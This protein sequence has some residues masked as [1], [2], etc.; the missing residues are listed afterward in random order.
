[1]TALD[2]LRVLADWNRD[3]EF[4]H[5]LSDISG[6]VLAA[7][8]SYGFNAPGQKMA[9][10]ATGQIVLDNNDGAFS[11][12][13][14]GALYGTVLR[15]DVLIQFQHTQGTTLGGYVITP[16]AMT[17]LRVI[18]I[19]IEPG[20]LSARTVV[21]TLGD[22]QSELMSAIYDP[23]LTLNTT[24]GVAIA[25]P[26]AEGLVPLSYAGQYWI[27]GASVLDTDTALFGPGQAYAS[28]YLGSTTLEYVG[29][30]IDRGG[31]VSLYSFIEEMCTAEMDGR[32]WLE[33]WP[34]YLGY[35]PR[36]RW[37]FM[38]RGDIARYYEPENTYTLPSSR[39]KNDGA[40]Y[41]YGR[42]ICNKVEVTLYPRTV[43]SVGTELGRSASTFRLKAGESRSITLRYRDPDNPD[44]TCSASTIIEPVASTDYTA[45]E[46]SDGSGADLT[47]SLSVV[48]E[49]RTSAAYLTVG[50]TGSTDL[51]VTLLKIRGTP[52]TAR[53]PVTIT[54]AD[55]QSI[56]DY[57]A[58][59]QS[60]TIAGVSDTELVQ[61]YA[62][63]Y[64]QRFK[65]PQARYRHVTFEFPENVSD[66]MY[67]PALILPLR[68]AGLRIEDDWIEDTTTTRI[69]WVAGVQHMVGGGT[70][71]TTWFLEDYIQQAFWQLA[72]SDLGV[73]DIS[74]RLGF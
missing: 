43:G 46:E 35:G 55:A 12:G 22:W 67:R 71:R 18:D 33:T 17:V 42:T 34:G 24:T 27:L 2:N 26:I 13:K 5:A 72:D 70:W 25:A 31:G 62:D 36:P 47:T 57:G 63:Y 68:F 56:H 65:D 69:H 52:L 50:N 54:S 15:R 38:G 74:T 58:Q 29:D 40:E 49:N 60:M 53:Q 7:S 73:L 37:R 19:Q 48:V 66:P 1:M 21:L 44:G 8:W 45:N 4:D 51:Y 39:F 14:T 10:P 6:R 20:A 3:G 30:N 9:P 28:F 59:S 11:V 32:F 61:S 16:F 41:E 64:I 23:P